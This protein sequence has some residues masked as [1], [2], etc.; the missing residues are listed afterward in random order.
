MP[1]RE[2]RFAMLLAKYDNVPLFPWGFVNQTTERIIGSIG[3]DEIAIHHS[4]A[5]K[6]QYFFWL[7]EQNYSTIQVPLERSNA[8]RSPGP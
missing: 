2:S 4:T 5:V 3:I 6:W 8:P 1:R 7:T